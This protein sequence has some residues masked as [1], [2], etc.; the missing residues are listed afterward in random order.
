LPASD[1]LIGR[2]AGLPFWEAGNDKRIFGGF[3]G[4]TVRFTRQQAQISAIR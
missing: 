4:L 2:H 1:E 3:W